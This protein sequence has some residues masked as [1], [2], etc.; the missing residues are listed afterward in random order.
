MNTSKNKSKSSEGKEY[1]ILKQINEFCNMA[2]SDIR[3]GNNINTL[4]FIYALR[5]YLSG[6]QQN[7]SYTKSKKYDYYQISSVYTS[8]SGDVDYTL[9]TLRQ[10][11]VDIN[12]S[13]LLTIL[14]KLGF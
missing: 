10:Q 4:D 1:V 7:L 8:C 3:A 13:Y 2:E 9:Y 5:K 12:R 14:Q 6:T 11:G